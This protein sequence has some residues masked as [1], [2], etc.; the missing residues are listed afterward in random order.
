LANYD[1][2]E[3][4]VSKWDYTIPQVLKRLEN[5]FP[6]RKTFIFQQDMFIGWKEKK[7]EK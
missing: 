6:G 4:L 3:F 1:Y 2:D 5:D 7:N